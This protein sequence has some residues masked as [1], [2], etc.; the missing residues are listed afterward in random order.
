MDELSGCAE[1][2]LVG[3][4]VGELLWQVE[5]VL[6]DALDGLD[7]T[8][9]ERG[10]FD[11]GHRWPAVDQDGARPALTAFARNLGP[12]EAEVVAEHARQRAQPRR[13]HRDTLAVDLQAVHQTPPALPTV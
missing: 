12:G 9:D 10:R 5:A 11:A 7:L 4:A 3:T 13:V 2:T 6:G 1:A 8:V